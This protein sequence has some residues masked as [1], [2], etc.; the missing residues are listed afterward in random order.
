MSEEVPLCTLPI[1]VN[2]VSRLDLQHRC[3][4]LVLGGLYYPSS[5]V[6]EAISMGGAD[7]KRPAILDAGTGTGAW[8]EGMAKAFPNA[9]ITAGDLAPPV[10]NEYI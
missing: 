6:E 5:F 4:T 10:P 7:G 2:E 1:T 3:V 8:A 9:D